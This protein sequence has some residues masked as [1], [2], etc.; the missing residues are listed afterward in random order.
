MALVL[1]LVTACAPTAPYATERSPAAIRDRG[2]NEAL[3]AGARFLDTYVAD[4]GRVVRPTHGADTVSEG[5]AYGM[6]IAVALGDRDRFDRIWR[7][8]EANLQRN[9]HLLSWHWANGAVD[10]PMPASD[11]DVDAAHALALATVA[12]ADPTYAD[13]AI[14]LARSVVEHEVVRGRLGHVE[15]AGPWAT[16]DRWVNPSYGAPAAYATLG[17]LTGD[18]V[19]GE[20]DDAARRVVEASTATSDLPPDWA[21][22][23]DRAVVASR[24]PGGARPQHGYDAARTA[25]RFAVDCDPAGR[26][27]AAAMDDEYDRAALPS[28]GPAA[29]LALDGR[30]L[31]H[32]GHPVATVA[33]A[34]AAA[35]DGQRDEA[36]QLLQLA[37]DQDAAHP[38]YYGAAWVALGWL[39]LTTDLL[40]GCGS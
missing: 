35:A 8:T 33:A 20:L 11:A 3:S 23:T 17:T 38:S 18:P 14:L 24:S 28:G 12:F 4:D 22:L 39:W 10:D 26:S 40:G 34:A 5:Q 19:W 32:D 25:V 31:T 2:A 29:V 37:S 7:W 6:L 16:T 30:P 15:V 36:L 9:D 21:R 27:L 1:V 13:Q